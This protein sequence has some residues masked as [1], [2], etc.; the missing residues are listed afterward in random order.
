MQE[1]HIIGPQR[2]RQDTWEALKELAERE[3]ISVSAV[4]RR[5]L[6]EGVQCEL[7]DT[8]HP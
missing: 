2:V 1:L 5:L 3:E 4:I 6:R 8:K 7:R